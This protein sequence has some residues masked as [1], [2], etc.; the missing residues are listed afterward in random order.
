MTFSEADAVG[1]GPHEGSGSARLLPISLAM[2][3]QRA[4]WV[5]LIA[6]AA[7]LGPACSEDGSATPTPEACLESRTWPDSR[8]LPA[9]YTRK[10]WDDASRI[11]V[12]ENSNSMTFD[13]VSTLKWRYASNGR[14]I[15]YLGV[16]QPFQHDYRYDDHDNVTEFLLSYPE[17]PDL[18]VPSTAGVWIGTKY[19]NEYE[20]SGR[21]AASTSTPMGGGSGEEGPTRGVYTEDAGGRCV[22]VEMTNTQG[23]AVE[24][25]TYDSQG[26][27]GGVDVSS[28]NYTSKRT[29]TYDE[30]NR[31]LTSALTISGRPFPG[32]STTT[33]TYLPDG[34]ERVMVDDGI[35]DIADERH[36]TV[37]RTAAC[38]AIDAAIGSQPDA[39]CRVFR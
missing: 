19:A 27:L 35:T 8:S 15:A 33:H 12:A 37:T 2:V 26:R 1:C 28:S 16:E 11:L 3:L 13:K 34:S 10:T 9:D 39:R 4:V 17:K 30:K 25:R 29:Y 22:T 5:L 20:P 38:L 18:L 36:V 23:K 14:T 6:G 24:T 21:L 32:T 7:W 31:V